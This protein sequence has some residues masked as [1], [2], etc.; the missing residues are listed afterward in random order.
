LLFRPLTTTLPLAEGFA[1]LAVTSAN[2]LRALH[3]RGEIPRLHSLPVFAVG[4]K[5]AALARE[6]GFAE[7]I[8]AGG[9]VDDLV[10]LLA[11]AGVD[12]PVLYPTARRHAGDLAKALAPHGIMVITSAVYEM[13][14][15]SRLG[16]DITAVDG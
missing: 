7:V 14:P 10:A 6:F 9:N 13:T 1:A 16:V 2:A 4:D 8:S 12:G 5:T 15:V 11:R 3:D